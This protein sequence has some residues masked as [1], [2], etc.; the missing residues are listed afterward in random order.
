MDKARTRMDSEVTWIWT[1]LLGSVFFE[2][3]KRVVVVQDLDG[4]RQ[5]NQLQLSLFAYFCPLLLLRRAVLLQVG[6]ELF[7]LNEP[8]SRISKIV[9]HRRDLHT[10]LRDARQ[11]LFYHLGERGDILLF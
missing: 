2:E 4:I 7:V 10:E 3:F 9:L 1:K 11:L 8:L 6:Q 5:S